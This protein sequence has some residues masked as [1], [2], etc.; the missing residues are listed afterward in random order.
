MFISYSHDSPEHAGRVLSL[1]KRPAEPEA[2]R[3]GRSARVG[4][5][6]ER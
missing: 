4:N 2:A 1:A 3:R 5:H 6:Y